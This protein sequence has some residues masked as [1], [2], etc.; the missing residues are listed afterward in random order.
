MSFPRY[1][2]LIAALVIG[3][4]AFSQSSLPV[5][6]LADRGTGNVDLLQLSGFDN[7]ALLDRDEASQ[8]FSN[9]EKPLQFAEPYDLTLTTA[10]RGTWEEI[11]GYQVWRLVID[12][13]TAY[14]LNL[15][16][17]RFELPEGASV[18]MYA[19][20]ETPSFRAF[21]AA[22]NNDAGE[23]WTPVV[24]GERIVVELNLPMGVTDYLLEIG[25]INHAYRPF[26][27]PGAD[28]SVGRSGACNVDVVCPEGDDYWDIIPA[29]GVYTRSGSWMCSGSAINN[30]AHDGTP[31]F[32]TA[33]HCGISSGNASTVVVYWN[34]QNSFCRP[35]GSSGGVGNGQL[36]QF[37]SGTILRGN[38]ST[39]DWALVE[40]SNEINPEYGITLAGWD[41]RNQ[42]TEHSVAIHHPSTNEKRI[43]FD[44]DPTQI[45]N[46]LQASPNPNGTH[47]HVINWELGTTEG[48]SSGSPLFSPENRIVGQLHGGYASCSS[49][50]ADWYGRVYTSMNGGMAQW[51]DPIGS[52]V[53]FID[54]FGAD[55]PIHTPDIPAGPGM[56]VYFDGM[57][58]FTSNPSTRLPNQPEV[59]FATWLTAEGP[60]KLASVNL[61]GESGFEVNVAEQDGDLFI[62]YAHTGTNGNTI[63]HVFTAQALGTDRHHVVVTRGGNPVGVRAFIDG[64]RVGN[65]FFYTVG[66]VT[67]GERTLEIGTDFVGI[68][69]E[70]RL[71]NTQHLQATLRDRISLS[72]A[73]GEG[74]ND[75]VAYFR[76]D[77]DTLGFV[78]DFAGN[79]LHGDIS[80]DTRIP[81]QFPV[82]ELAT[83][84][85]TG[86]S[87]NIGQEGYALAIVTSGSMGNDRLVTLYQ[88][89]PSMEVVTENLPENIL[90]RTETIWGAFAVG[91][92]EAALSLDVSSL[93][94]VD[95]D[96]VNSVL[97]RSAPNMPW[98]DATELWQ[99]NGSVFQTTGITEFGEWSAGFN[100]EV[101]TEGQTTV[102]AF[103]LSAAYPNPFTNRT[104][105]T[106]SLSEASVVSVE[107]VDLLGRQVMLLHDGMTSAGTISLELDGSLLAPGTY[108]IRATGEHAITVRRVTLVR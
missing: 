71:H 40:M 52:G 83:T 20:G 66:P 43:T 55:P 3:P 74:P 87:A 22:D 13:P 9:G 23:L 67:E 17:T 103:E 95:G 82:G 98:V 51:L 77:A 78:Y 49:I 34:Y 99:R 15:G 106:L 19:E 93:G 29:I 27:I 5:S 104:T 60:G 94:T 25:H 105:V 70:V 85:V 46:Y 91:E 42:I 7:E 8:L 45:T 65:P 21:T 100:P 6:L 35:V 24:L 56:S 38:S 10:D 84:L 54:A 33:N 102:Q 88:G 86:T 76:F 58:S 62:A 80:S 97:Y 41:R 101:S 26:G 18:W 39:A 107:V 1:F 89:Y 92:V 96:P 11:D 68:L 72:Y 73:T 4:H 16:F 69:D 28:M 2:L 108:L 31:Y 32:L 75:L 90:W 64:Y 44:N 36:T 50:T 61:D 30:T 63:E 81:S 79:F 53:D 59:T 57:T 48:G 37:N 12:S 14:S 47:L